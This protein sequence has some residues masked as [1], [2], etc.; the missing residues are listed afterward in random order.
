MELTVKQSNKRKKEY[1][2]SYR[3][4]L[5]LEK[6]LSDEINRLRMD[7]QSPKSSALDSMPRRRNTEADLSDYTVRID[8]LLTR[9]QAAVDKRIMIRAEIGELLEQLPERENL[10]LYL[11]Y[12]RGLSFRDIS[13]RMQYE[14]RQIY[15]I[16]G[17]ALRHFPLRL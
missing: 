15:R 17:D 7:M 11:R 6:E 8:T 16:H 5:E 4:I 10:L 9:L 2:N 1:L 12:I 3:D 13:K 14:E